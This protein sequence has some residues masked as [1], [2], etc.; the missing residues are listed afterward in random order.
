[1]DIRAELKELMESK[2]YSISYLSTA[3]G[4]AKSTISMWMN[5]NYNGKNDKITDIINNFIQREKERSINNDL[6]FVDISIVKYIS[7][8]A[9]LCHTQ[10]KIGVCAGRA[11]LGKTIA[12]KK[13]TKEFLDSI[14]IESDSGYTAKSLLKEIHR[15]LSL[16]GRGCVYDLMDEVVRKLNQSGRLLIIDEAENLPYRALEITRRIHDK[17]GIGVLLIGRSILLENL[18]GFNNQYDQLY[19]RVKYTKIIDRLILVDVVKILETI[20]LDSKLAETYLQYSDG[21]TRRLEHLISHSIS[22][23]KINGKAEVDSAVIK[24]TSKL[25]MV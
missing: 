14:L 12:V 18:K 17:T 23:A 7:E 13:Y 22:I 10:G 21:N 2:N 8:I 15:R 25:L 5:N 19:S 9:R 1:M 4:I 3:T 11:G 24:K 16:S 6:P 20:G